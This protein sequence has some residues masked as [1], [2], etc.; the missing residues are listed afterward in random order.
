MAKG[1][2]KGRRSNGFARNR[3]RLT[4]PPEIATNG[5]FAAGERIVIAGFAGLVLA[6]LPLAFGG[7]EPRAYWSGVAL[8]GA[9]LVWAAARDPLAHRSL[10][11]VSQALLAVGGIALLALAQGLFEVSW[12]P[13]ASLRA[14]ASWLAIAL[15][16]ALG[17]VLGRSRRARRTL[18]LS[19]VAGAVVQSIYGVTHWSKGAR[20]IFGVPVASQPQRLKGAFVNPNHFALLA[21]VALLALQ[22]WIWWGL[23]QVREHD[24]RRDAPQLLVLP[25]ALWGLILA[26]LLLSGSRSGMLGFAL[27]GIVQALVLSTASGRRLRGRA[28]VRA[29]AVLVLALLLVAAVALV[30]EWRVATE[31]W[32]ST[33]WADVSLGARLA[34]WETTASL[35]SAAPLVGVGFGAFLDAFPQA[36]DERFAGVSWEH[37]HNDWLELAVCG[38]LIGVAL[39]GCALVL[40]ARRALRVLSRGRRSEDRAAGLFACGVLVAAGVQEFFEFALLAPGNALSLALLLGAACGA[41]SLGP[42]PSAS[43]TP[44]GASGRPS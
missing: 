43:E 9:C 35:W 16:I 12:A 26:A 25:I 31:R 24:R 37:A 36:A 28:M 32:R 19:V 17:A 40:L 34:A 22:A 8:L 21:V 39:A 44:R 20:D 41:L 6:G 4:E 10:R 33:T 30:L 3:E 18:L 42:E 5:S 14:A 7:F 15:A 38:G 27:G 29:L 11:R 2:D 13:R 1:L 23:R